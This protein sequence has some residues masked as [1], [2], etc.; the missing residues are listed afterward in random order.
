MDSIAT[1][2]SPVA[3]ATAWEMATEIHTP[4]RKP[5]TSQLNMGF[6][7]MF[8]IQAVTAAEETSKRCKVTL[9]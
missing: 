2:T 1:H 8:N 3:G 9:H 7:K 5:V 4:R 6:E